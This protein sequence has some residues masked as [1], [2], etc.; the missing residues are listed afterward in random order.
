VRDFIQLSLTIE[1]WAPGEAALQVA[2]GRLVLEHDSH[3]RRVVVDRKSI[4][5]QAP[6]CGLHVG[7]VV[8]L[9]VAPA[10]RRM[11]DRAPYTEM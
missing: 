10:L 9:G 7:G 8:V 11:V 6:P 2:I 4:E 1:S 3:D 5:R